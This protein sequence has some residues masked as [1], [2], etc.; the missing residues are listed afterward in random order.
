MTERLAPAATRSAN[1][2]GYHPFAIAVLAAAHPREPALTIPASPSF[3]TPPRI[4]LCA[5]EASGDLLGAGLIEALRKRYPDA[6][7]AGIGGEQMR[8]AG[9]DAWHDA[10]ELAVMGLSEVL[11]HLPR[12]LRLR[13]EFR[14]RLLDVA[15]GRV[16]RH[17]RA[18]LQP[19]RG[20]VAAPARRAHRA[21]RQPVGV[22]VARE[23]RR[24]RSARSADRVLCLFP[25]EPAIYARHGVDAR[26][27]G[28]P[29]ADEMPLEPDRDG[30][31]RASSDSIR[32]G[33]CW[34]L[35]PGSRVG[36][37]ERLGADFLAAAARLLAAGSAAAGRGADGQR[38]RQR[39][40]PARA[41]RTPRQHRAD[42]G[43]ARDPRPGAHADDRQR[44]GAAG[45]RHG[46]ARGDAGQAADGGGLQGRRRRLTR[47]SRAWACSRSTT[48]RCPTCSPANA[49]CRN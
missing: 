8:A 34:Q 31:A 37:I 21:L 15:A 3:P 49:S 48:T 40:V 1:A 41:G 42:A 29:L 9:F 12:L 10:R 32:H 27:V 5:G 28:H 43:P 38:A 6:E 13:R 39:G 44:R 26:F 16:H 23:A 45:V 47:W 46:H 2:R 20:E 36:E 33:H 25:M 11:R 14:Q 19:R 4:A 17:R 7:F 22:G 30:S 18:R 24:R 35:L